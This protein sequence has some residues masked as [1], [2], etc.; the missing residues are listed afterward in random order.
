MDSDNIYIVITGS[1]QFLWIKA[2]NERE[3]REGQK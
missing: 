1:M 2:V 3:Y